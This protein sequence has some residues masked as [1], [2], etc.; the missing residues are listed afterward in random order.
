MSLK[1][2]DFCFNETKHHS[3]ERF[4]AMIQGFIEVG[5]LVDNRKSMIKA[6]YDKIDL[7]G[8]SV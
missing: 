3:S 2:Q 4:R 8:K 7:D 1:P 6:V 5:N